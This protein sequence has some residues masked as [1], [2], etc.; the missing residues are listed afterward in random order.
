MHWIN[1]WDRSDPIATPIYAPNDKRAAAMRVDNVSVTSMAFPEPAASHSSYFTNKDVVEQLFRVAILGESSY[2]EQPPVP[3]GNGSPRRRL[4]AAQIA[5][6]ALPWIV[7]AAIVVRMLDAPASVADTAVIVA[8]AMSIV[9]A[10]GMVVARIAGAHP[11]LD[12]APRARN[13]EQAVPPDD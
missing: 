2:R 9:L 1:V 7:A 5:M 13:P 3:I 10:I 12:A 8:V 4:G 11:G 6:L